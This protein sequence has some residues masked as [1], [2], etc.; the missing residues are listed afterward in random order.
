MENIDPMEQERT[1]VIIK[2]DGVQR[3]LI[4]EIIQR[5]ERTGL[6]L[7]ATKFL[8]ADSDK[9]RSHYVINDQWVKNTGEKVIKNT[10]G[11]NDA[12]EE[13]MKRAGEEVL[14]VLQK[15][16]TSGPIVPMVWEGAQA[17]KVVRKLVGDTEPLSSDIGTIRG[18]YVLDSYKHADIQKRAVR[19]LIHASSCVEEASKEIEIWFNNK[20]IVPYRVISDE[21]LYNV[22][23]DNIL[24]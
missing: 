4:G 18:D 24:R 23:I 1:L 21:I 5:F 9:V 16:M 8:V 22:N 11:K 10:L 19:N 15:F 14:N 6:K 12:T 7:V 20:E 3:S 17:V 13:E 2:P